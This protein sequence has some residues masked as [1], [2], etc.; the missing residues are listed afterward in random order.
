MRSEKC[1]IWHDMRLEYG[2]MELLELKKVWF[3]RFFA[4]SGGCILCRKQK[5]Q[6]NYLENLGCT[7]IFSV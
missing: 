2:E 7:E 4:W 1:K 5:K 6:R 3:F